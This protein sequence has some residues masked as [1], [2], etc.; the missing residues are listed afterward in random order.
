M[1]LN[2]TSEQGINVR[3][4]IFFQVVEDSSQIGKKPER[5]KALKKPIPKIEEPKPATRSPSPPTTTE[6]SGC[7]L[8]IIV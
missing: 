1:I 7:T 8:E 3:M 4:L 5:G 2:V 6:V